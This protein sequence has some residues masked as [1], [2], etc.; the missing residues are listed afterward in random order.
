MTSRALKPHRLTVTVEA[1]DPSGHFS[2]R[3]FIELLGRRARVC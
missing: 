2:L 1:T 3:A